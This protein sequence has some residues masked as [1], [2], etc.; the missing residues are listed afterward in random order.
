MC[1]WELALAGAALTASVG[2]TVASAQSTASYRDALNKAQQEKE[3]ASEAARQAESARQ[4]TY[5]DESNAAWQA[6]LQA[7][8]PDAYKT[9]MDTGT[10]QTQATTQQVQQESNINKGLLPGQ[11]GSSVSDVFT[12][13]AATQ[14]A[15]RTA[16]ATKRIAALAQLAG[17]D[18][19]NGQL[20]SSANLYNADQILR[21]SK[22]SRSLA[23]GQ[24]EE[25]SATPYTTQGDTSL[26]SGLSGL[27]NLGV[28][29]AASEGA[30]KGIGS[31][32]GS[33]FS[34]SSTPVAGTVSL[35]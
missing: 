18:R 25:D 29:V 9:A 14:G 1:S 34:G 20:T 11:T 16:E 30:F 3:A 33:I 5:E 7:Q 6:Q 28:Q 32:L 19:A 17:Y 8:S 13:E 31:Q 10:A 4:K 12:K 27:G 22:A 35:W 23:L 15:T 2:G 26:Y 24:Q 21:N